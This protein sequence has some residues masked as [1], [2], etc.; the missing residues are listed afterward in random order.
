MERVYGWEQ[1]DLLSSP[2]PDGAASLKDARLQ[3]GFRS[4]SPQGA[5]RADLSPGSYEV[6]LLFGARGGG[7]REAPLRMYVSLQ[8]RRVLSDFE[9]GTYQQP[10]LRTFPVRL[11]PGQP[12][13]VI[14]ERA[15]E[16]SEWGL[17]AMV[18]R[19]AR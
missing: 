9:G 10:V 8:G 17:N 14:F 13:R 6:E 11:E 19:P 2:L 15:N 5:F 18:V 1:G 4:R 3:S 7:T 12:L 16:G